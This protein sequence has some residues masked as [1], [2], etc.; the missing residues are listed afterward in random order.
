MGNK[1]T[2]LALALIAKNEERCIARLINSVKSI[3]RQIVVVDTGSTDKTVEIAKSLGA[4]VYYFKWIN[5]FS[6]AKNYALS[7]VKADWVLFFDADEWIGE[8]TEKYIPEILDSVT[9]N[10]HLICLEMRNISEIAI[11]GSYVI[12]NRDYVARIFRTNV[13]L[14]F[15]YRIHEYLSYKG[16]AEDNAV[17][18]IPYDVE[19]IILYHDGYMDATIADHSERN[20]QMLLA[21]SKMDDPHPLV[22]YYIARESYNI[23][24]PEYSYEHSKRFIQSKKYFSYLPLDNYVL[25]LFSFNLLNDKPATEIMELFQDVTVLYPRHPAAYILKG[26]AHYINFDYKNMLVNME[27]GLSMID[28]YKPKDESYISTHPKLYALG[29]AY[30]AKLY[31]TIFEQKK[32]SRYIEKAIHYELNNVSFINI[33]QLIMK[34]EPPEKLFTIINKKLSAQ[35]VEFVKSALGVLSSFEPGWSFLA[36]YNKLME[37]GQDSDLFKTRMLLVMEQYKAAYDRYL[38]MWSNKID[39]IAKALGTAI[40]S[41]EEEL[42]NDIYEKGDET[43]KRILNAL[44]GL[45]GDLPQPDDDTFTLELIEELLNIKPKGHSAALYLIGNLSLQAEINAYYVTHLLFLHGFYEQAYS[46]AKE[47]LKR[48]YE[49]QKRH[50]EMLAMAMQCAYFFK[51]Y[52][53][54]RIYLEQ[55]KD[56]GLTEAG[57]MIQWVMDQQT[58]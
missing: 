30:M 31:A 22:D 46:F 47:G 40:A 11:D 19:K 54:V 39:S 32:A 50:A 36:A 57:H 10:D 18:Y 9:P 42:L 48:N 43:V 16:S 34:D 3:C 8:G 4:E 55:A 44:C 2:T 28:S 53:N 25:Y 6:A 7:K 51:E 14:R 27:K 45:D 41:G 5:D 15:K 38:L 33:A 56:V 26:C 35:S 29:Y 12:M 17:R 49:S 24:R 20:L 21:E 52:E 23:N 37:L 1:K 58:N 13:G